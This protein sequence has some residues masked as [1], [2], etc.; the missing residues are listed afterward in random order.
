MDVGMLRRFAG[1]AGILALSALI[2]ANAIGQVST[3]NL[4]WL[5]GGVAVHD[6]ASGPG[7]LMFSSEPAQIRFSDT[8][9]PIGASE[10]LI[11][12]QRVGGG[13]FFS[14]DGAWRAFSP[15]P[16]DRLVAQ[17]VFG[18]N[19]VELL[20][21]QRQ[22]IG[23]IAAGWLNSDLRVYP[24]RWD[25]D[26]NRGEYGIHGSYFTFDSELPEPADGLAWFG[27]GDTG[28]GVVA[29]DWARNSAFVLFSQSPVRERVP[30]IPVTA[31]N[32]LL[33]VA[34]FGSVW[35]AA[36]ND[37]WID[38]E[39]RETDFLVARVNLRTKDSVLEVG[40]SGLEDGVALG[41]QETDIEVVPNQYGDR[42]N[43]GEFQVEG[44]VFLSSI[45]YAPAG[46]RICEIRLPQGFPKVK[47]DAAGNI[48]TSTDVWERLPRP[49]IQLFVD[50]SGSDE[51]TGDSIEPLR[52]VAEA[53]RR[54][55][56][57]RNASWIT[58]GPGEYQWGNARPTQDTAI[59]GSGIG[60]TWIIGDDPG[61]AAAE[62]RHPIKLFVANVT[63]SGG[64][65]GLDARRGNELTTTSVSFENVHGQDGLFVSDFE[66]VWV[67][68]SVARN[69]FED[70]FSYTTHSRSDM[71]VL[72][73][74]VLATNNGL[75]GN[76]T[77]QGSSA[78]NDVEIVRIAGQYSRNAVNIGDIARPTS[79]N[80]G[81]TMLD[82]LGL[83][84]LHYVISNTNSAR[85]FES[86]VDDRG[87]VQIRQN[88]QLKLGIGAKDWVRVV[89]T[90]SAVSAVPVSEEEN[91]GVFCQ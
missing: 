11:A 84:R 55:N 35:R 83:D 67:V 88:G 4:G 43:Y 74:R 31:A 28:F 65:I 30:Q 66:S 81:I 46:H 23:G 63:F 26:F 17:V 57:S 48:T 32:N 29:P 36:T 79:Y 13:W 70:G 42:Y 44:T 78:H 7:Y 38:F 60:S 75:S 39:A 90:L 15:R 71:K 76:N 33:I 58:V 82:P 16:S 45:D 73:Q 40:A 59:L 62:S 22:P 53:I 27:I 69:N 49:T 6:D 91:Q 20:Q 72:E 21:G 68:D 34:R 52:S 3:A 18:S 25:D 56:M 5:G 41:V 1:A 64:R 87:V 54:A 50:E 51:N 24:D 14:D 8:G 89:D 19:G 61:S 2:A 80:I 37:S 47:I 86:T 85:V 9:Y 10:H 77:A 12:V